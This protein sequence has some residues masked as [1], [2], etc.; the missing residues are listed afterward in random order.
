V[1]S[2][3]YGVGLDMVA[4]GLVDC[5]VADVVLERFGFLCFAILVG[6]KAC[7]LLAMRGSMRLLSCERR[8]AAVDTTVGRCEGALQ[9]II[10]TTMKDLG[11]SKGL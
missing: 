7:W 3:S 5:R 11:S 2:S 1:L 6:G 4:S 9:G 10:E 8:G